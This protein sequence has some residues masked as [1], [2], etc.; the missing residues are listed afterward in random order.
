MPLRSTERSDGRQRPGWKAGSQFETGEQILARTTSDVAI[1]DRTAWMTNRAE[2]P[3]RDRPLNA[4]ADAGSQTE[5]RRDAEV[6]L[7]ILPYGR[8]MKGPPRRISRL[9]F[10][11]YSSLS[12]GVETTPPVRGSAGPLRPLFA[13]PAGPNQGSRP[14]STSIRTNGGDPAGRNPTAATEI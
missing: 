2:Q 12:L 3:A 13:G 5:S 10:A 8:E 4:E 9:A 11:R 6:R 7:A 1:T 14:R